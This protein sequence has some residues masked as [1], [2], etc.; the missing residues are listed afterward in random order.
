[1]VA[2]GSGSIPHGGSQYVPVEHASDEQADRYT[3]VVL[4]HGIGDE[5]RNETL[6]EALNALTYWFTQIAGLALRPS[7][8]GRVWVHT[9]LTNDDDP[10]SPSS[11]AT[12]E[13]EAPSHV[14]AQFAA[15]GGNRPLRLEIREVWWAQSFGLP[16]VG[17]SLAWATRQLWEELHILWPRIG[18]SGLASAAQRAPAR[19]TPQA[20][21]Y[22]PVAQTGGAETV[23]NEMTR[24]GKRWREGIL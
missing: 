21:T 5:K 13:L 18:H 11:R 23:H 17:T 16:P 6:Q 20:V 9:D 15:V 8:A 2:A 19:E 1:M 7:G 14:A 12:L 4:I 22:R 3:G 24:W 10:D